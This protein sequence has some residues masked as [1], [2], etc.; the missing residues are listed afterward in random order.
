V[1]AL[2]SSIAQSDG[3]LLCSPEYNHGIS[4]V[5]N[6]ALDWSRASGLRSPL[7]NKAYLAVTSSAVHALMQRSRR[8]LSAHARI[9]MRPQVVIAGVMQKIVGGRLADEVTIELCPEVIDDLLKEIRL[10]SLQKG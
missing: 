3:I 8:L 6:N 7:K 9:L 4:G 10:L 2:K 1:R 5:L